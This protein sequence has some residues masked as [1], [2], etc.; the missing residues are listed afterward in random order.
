MAS[1]C[2]SVHV[3]VT[4][5]CRKSSNRGAV[6]SDT[7]HCRLLGASWNV[8]SILQQ[9][10]MPVPRSYTR[11]DIHYTAAVRRQPW[12]SLFSSTDPT[13]HKA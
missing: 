10:D 5:Q 2:I 12:C 11:L 6:L 9:A 3:V 8:Y 1:T 13:S 7:R 4:R